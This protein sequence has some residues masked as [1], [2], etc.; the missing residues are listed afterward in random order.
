MS[1]PPEYPGERSNSEKPFEESHRFVADDISEDEV[2]D[3]D[4]DMLSVL[5]FIRFIPERDFLQQDS[6]TQESP[7]KAPLTWVAS[8]LQQ[9]HEMVSDF[10]KPPSEQTDMSNPSP[11]T[12][13][14]PMSPSIISMTGRANDNEP[15]ENETVTLP[16][17]TVKPG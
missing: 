15:L 10:G 17:I 16:V 2:P 7:A 11:R 8:K 13:G 1:Y 5:G 6:E 3:A 12:V 14:L 4:V 9:S